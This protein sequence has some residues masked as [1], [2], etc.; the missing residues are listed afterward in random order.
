MIDL[1]GQV[2]ADGVSIADRPVNGL[3]PALHPDAMSSPAYQVALGFPDPWTIL[4]PLGGT[5]ASGPLNLETRLE[6]MMSSV[7]TLGGYR[8]ES[9]M[10]CT[11]PAG[12]R[13]IAEARAVVIDGVRA[14]AAV[15]REVGSRLSIEPMR[16]SFRAVRSIVCSLPETLDLLA[17]VDDREVGIAFDLW[18]MWD[19]PEVH[20]LIPECVDLFH[21]VQVADYRANTRGP[22]DRV[23]AGAGIADIPRL[24]RELRSAGFDG[25]YD[26]EIFSDDGR[27]G[28]RYEDSLW[29]LPPEEFA[30]RQMEGFCACW[31]Q[32]D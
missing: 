28:S 19:S 14:L 24:L 15:A 5:I 12:D 4:P 30:T 18:H 2:R 25:W 16:E 26:L 6:Q 29:K 7:R 21:A 8:P 9:I 1:A 22:M 31:S 3:D 13:P 23:E 27:F 20:T 32:S 11:G 17:K 10:I